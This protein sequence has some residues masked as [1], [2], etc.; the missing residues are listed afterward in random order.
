MAAAPSSACSASDT[1]GKKPAHGA[2]A[3]CAEVAVHC[4]PRPGMKKP[5][6][7]F[8]GTVFWGYLVGPVGVEPTT[9][10]LA[11]KE[12]YEFLNLLGPYP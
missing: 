8:C 3:V 4:L 5:R 2:A 12:N 10:G 6:C 7:I 1:T 11:D 9:N